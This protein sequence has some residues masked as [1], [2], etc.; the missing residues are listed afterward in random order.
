MVRQKLSKSERI[1]LLF[2]ELIKLNESF[3]DPDKANA[4]IRYCLAEI[5]A[6]H[7]ISDLPMSI[8]RL[9]R[10]GYFATERIHFSETVQHLIIIHTDG[11]YAI[12][13]KKKDRNSLWLS[14]PSESPEFLRK[15]LS[16]YKKGTTKKVFICDISGKTIWKNW[17]KK[18]R[19]I[20]RPKTAYL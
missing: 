18:K 13:E 19:K 7:A 1:E 5:E 15:D 4:H 14:Y 10:F 6:E 16:F 12:Y 11:A 2:K 17:P 3:N 20:I 9:T 8:H